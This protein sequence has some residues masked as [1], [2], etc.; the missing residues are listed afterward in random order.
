MSKFKIGDIVYLNSKSKIK[1][2][3]TYLTPNG[4]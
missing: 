3:V 1:L 4:D 2:T